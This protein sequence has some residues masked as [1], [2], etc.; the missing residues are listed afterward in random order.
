MLCQFTGKQKTNCSLDFSAGDGGTLVVMS[1]TGGLGGNSFE[2]VVH[3]TV[4]DGHRLARNTGV[5]MYLFQHFV[6]VNCVTFLPPALLLF[7][8]LRDVFLSLSGFFG[9]F[10]ACLGWH[11]SQKYRATA[12]TT[13][14]NTW[15]NV[16]KPNFRVPFIKS[17]RTFKPRPIQFPS[18]SGEVIRHLARYKFEAIVCFVFIAS[19]TKFRTVTLLVVVCVLQ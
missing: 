16:T 14:S 11:D 5:G 15:S 3:E 4:H 17:T 7:V 1:Q 13:H 2:Y 8:T 12:T 10:T 6:D 18:H 9:S 19:T